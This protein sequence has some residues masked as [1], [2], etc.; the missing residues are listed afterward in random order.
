MMTP[1][2][3]TAKFF[4]PVNS[5]SLNEKVHEMATSQKDVKRIARLFDCSLD[6][7]RTITF[8]TVSDCGIGEPDYIVRDC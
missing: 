3:I 7:V 2:Q 1:V 4:M 8:N 5:G 6:S